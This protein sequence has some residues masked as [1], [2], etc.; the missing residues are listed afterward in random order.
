MLL[1]KYGTLEAQNTGHVNDSLQK[2]LEEV[3][4]QYKKLKVR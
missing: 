4:L 3:N 2:D 1:V